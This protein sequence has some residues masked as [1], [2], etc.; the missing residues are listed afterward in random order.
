MHDRHRGFGLFHKGRHHPFEIDPPAEPLETRHAAAEKIENFARA[1]D[2]GEHIAAVSTE[3]VDRGNLDRFLFSLRIADLEFQ[4]VIARLDGKMAQRFVASG[5]ELYN[6]ILRVKRRL[7]GGL[8]A[9]HD[10]SETRFGGFEGKHVGRN[11]A[12]DLHQFFQHWKLV[13]HE[14]RNCIAR[15]VYWDIVDFA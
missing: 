10:Q 2:L 13:L 12:L 4:Q 15:N 9:I 14:R 5:D 6:A 3:A 11:V 8:R 1:A 7:E